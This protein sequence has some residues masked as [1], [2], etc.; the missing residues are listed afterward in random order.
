MF[1]VSECCIFV[2]DT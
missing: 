2:T 1:D